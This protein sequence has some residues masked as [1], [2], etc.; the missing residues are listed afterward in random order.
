MEQIEEQISIES[1]DVQEEQIRTGKGPKGPY[2]F[3]RLI[4]FFFLPLLA[5]GAIVEVVLWRAGETLPL[6]RVIATQQGNAD[7]TFMRGVMDQ[8]FYRYKFLN[9]AQQ[10]PKVLALG[11]SR[12]MEFRSQMFGGA[13][14]N[15]YNA[16]GMIQ[17]LRDLKAFTENLG[18]ITTPEVVLLG[19]D[20]W[21]LSGAH[22]MAN[23]L[24]PG[25]AYEAATDW[26]AHLKAVRRFKSKRTLKP[27]FKSMFAKNGNIGIEARNANVGFRRDGSMQYAFAIPRTAAEWKFVDRERPPVL[28]RIRN[29][30]S[31][32]RPNAGVARERATLLEECVAELARK[33][34]MVLGFFPPFSAEAAAMMESTPGQAALWKEAHELVPTIFDKHGQVFVNGSTTAR[35][36]LDDRYLIDGMHGAETLQAHLLL[37]FLESPRVAEKFPGLAD[38]LKR[39]ISDTATNPWLPKYAASESR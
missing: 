15:F 35:L 11:S 27:A 6:E 12:V 25:I 26:Q 29:G 4:L 9:I 32:F 24:E 10:K 30:E 8:G 33:N 18:K 16:G 37:K 20:I 21:W 17:N 22:S 5:I 34:V 7:V 36:G 39:S 2:A 13:R 28:E 3:A 31:P 14:G 23:G 38:Y 19:V 1:A